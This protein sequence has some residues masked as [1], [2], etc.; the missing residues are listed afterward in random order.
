MSRFT[1]NAYAE[2]IAARCDRR[3][4]SPVTR[5]VPLARWWREPLWAKALLGAILVYATALMAWN[6]SRGGD[7]S[8]YEASARSMSQSWQAF[9][10]GAFD[11]SATVTLDK[12]S[13]FAIPQALSIR[14]FGMS[15][16]AVALPQVV[17][18]LVTVLACA[19]VGLR[20][21]GRGAGLV[22]AAAAASTPVFVS[23]FGH[24]MEDG[25][26]TMALAV[27][28]VWWQRAV[29][30]RRWWPLVV[31]ALFVGV[32]FQAKMM[33]AWFV[34]PGLVLATVVAFSARRTVPEGALPRAGTAVPQQPGATRSRF[35]LGAALVRA[36]V[37][38]GVSVVASIAWMVV[39]EVLPA[40]ARPFIDGSTDNDVFAMVFGYN[41]LDRFV[42]GA[43]PGAVSGRT[44]DALHT[45]AGGAHD[46]TRTAMTWTHEAVGA[47]AG[48]SGST[49]SVTKLFAPPLVSQIGWLYVA[50]FA[51][52]A[53]GLW[54][55]WPRRGRPAT[56]RAGFATLVAV[57]VW[58]ATAVA[59]LSLARVPHTAYVA[60]IGVQLAL[61]A[62]VAWRECV[63]LLRAPRRWQRLVPAALAVVQGA[64]WVVLAVGS[65][66]PSA[67]AVT[68]FALLAIGVVLLVA[69]GLR[70]RVVSRRRGIAP[71]ALA[72]ALL[73]GPAVFSAQVVDAGRDG[74][75]GDA[76]VG[77]KTP[78]NEVFHVS[79]PAVWGGEPTLS[80][81]VTQLVDRAEAEGAG[82]GG[83]PLFVTD[84][85]AISS[86]IIAATGDRVLTD[87]GYS[88]SVPVFTE[89]ALATMV[90][91]GGP[92]LFVVQTGAP[93]SDPVRQLVTADHCAQQQ[94]WTDQTRPEPGN[95]KASG[96]ALY[97]C[98]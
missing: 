48:G 51:G 18:G 44:G 55:W 11:P 62:A 3:I 31:A 23:M 95:G 83:A 92:R 88:G 53:L 60:G 57:V 38:G 79:T 98:G 63:R 13:G 45:A 64:W 75:G 30:T 93:P 81:P 9:L 70:V 77:L 27:A 97:A 10:F 32:G 58:L 86:Q 41:G 82:T 73:C 5:P 16:S 61:L 71:A 40:S 20:W 89:S 76:Y 35:A 37:L 25:L 96:F 46:V 50:A 65:R 52:I 69:A 66:M 22:A 85:W 17:E 34:L 36:T 2:H 54:R 91:T 68:M 90:R 84:S 12:L 42:P 6:L 78:S 59:V 14:L 49:D 47:A 21:A 29:I 26:L 7:F 56:D 72:V 8:F 19:V 94:W 39:V 28:L 87:G 43:V 33:S 4:L 74:S 80:P 24:P 15:T 1:A 67:M